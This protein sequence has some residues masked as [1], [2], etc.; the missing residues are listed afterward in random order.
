MAKVPASTAERPAA[1]SSDS[2]SIQS[3]F[4]LAAFNV[5]GLLIVFF[6]L[7]LVL[8]FYFKPE[9]PVPALDALK[10]FLAGLHLD[11]F[12]ALALTSPLMIWLAI[13]P[14]KWFGAGWHQFLVRSIFWLFWAIQVFLLFA[15][16][17][18]FEEFK[19]RF[20]TVAVDYLRD[21]HEVFVNIW[22]TYPVGW[23]VA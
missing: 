12:V 15:E 23:V 7:R 18:F 22:D 5:L 1:L 4:G 10:A 21:P 11:L 19:S 3:R 17:F 2:Q 6:T 9:A 20:N 8:F 16:F 14:A 13:V